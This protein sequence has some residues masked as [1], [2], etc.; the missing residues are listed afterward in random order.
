MSQQ[1]EHITKALLVFA[2]L[3]RGWIEMQL[4]AGHQGVKTRLL[5]MLLHT[6][7]MPMRYY[8]RLLGISKA[9]MTTLVDECTQADLVVRTPD[10]HDRRASQLSL[11]AAGI[12]FAEHIWSHYVAQTAMI[13]ETVPEAH[14]EVFL[15]VCAQLTERMHAMG[16]G[17]G[18]VVCEQTSLSETDE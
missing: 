7:Y 16:C 12:E 10:T 8:A 17:S 11:T 3:Y 6:P 9:H 15:S 14:R 18:M 1:T 4:A 5:V 13:L 2:P